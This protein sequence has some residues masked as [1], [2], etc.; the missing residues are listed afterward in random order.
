MSSGGAQIDKK[1]RLRPLDTGRGKKEQAPGTLFRTR[2]G[3]VSEVLADKKK[4]L[5]QG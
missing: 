3:V 4:T 2:M 1:G 5:L